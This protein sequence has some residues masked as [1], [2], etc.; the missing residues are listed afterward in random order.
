MYNR[1]YIEVA[2]D[3]RDLIS[4][5]DE[6]RGEIPFF[7]LEK[8]LGQKNGIPLSCSQRKHRWGFYIVLLKKKSLN[9]IR[10]RKINKWSEIRWR[11]LVSN[12]QNGY[13]SWYAGVGKFLSLA[14]TKYFPLGNAVSSPDQVHKKIEDFNTRIPRHCKPADGRVY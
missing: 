1:S 14:S 5:A 12:K 10:E 11:T 6:K 7:H 13:K 4:D 3:F 9:K 8:S 2:D